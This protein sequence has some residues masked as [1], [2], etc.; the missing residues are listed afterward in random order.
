MELMKT[1]EFQSSSER[2]DFCAGGVPGVDQA[3]VAQG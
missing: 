1:E 3:G 2:N